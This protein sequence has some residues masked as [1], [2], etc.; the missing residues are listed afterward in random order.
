MAYERQVQEHLERLDQSLARLRNL[1][2][3]G[4]NETAIRFMEEGELKDR[5]EELQN[6][7]NISKTGNFGARGV[8]NTRSL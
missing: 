4:E 1:I 3:R 5:Y 7:I 8:Q 2:K 6:I